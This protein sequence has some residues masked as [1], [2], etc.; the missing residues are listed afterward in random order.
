VAASGAQASPGDAAAIAAFLAGRGV[1]R[2]ARI[3]DAPCGLGRRA[4]ALAEEGFHVTAVDPNSVGIEAARARVPASLAARL[5]F[6]CVPKEE[7]PGPTPRERVDAVLCLDHALARGTQD[8]DLALLARFADRLAPSGVLVVELLNRDFFTARP[9]PF[10][11]HVVGNLE[12]HEFRTFDPGTGVLELR[13]EVY[14]REGQDL[15]H[16]MDSS[17]TL[18][19][20]TPHEARALL[21]TAGWELREIVGGWEGEALGAD[22]RKLLLVAQRARP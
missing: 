22:R 18:R 4:L 9:R 11:F 5:H 13:W 14:E 10:A 20:L 3:L 19:L 2:G 17:A 6:V 15:R 16:R 21:E 12:Q 8:E 7:L 1:K